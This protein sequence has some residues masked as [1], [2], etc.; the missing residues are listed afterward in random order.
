MKTYILIALFLFPGWG[1]LAQERLSLDDCRQMALQHSERI[2]IARLQ[3]EKARAEEAAMRTSYLPALSAN[4]TGLYLHNSIDMEFTLPTL[5]PDPMTGQLVPNVMTHP[6]S[7]D[8]ITGPDGNPVFNMYAWLP[9]EV[10]L[11]G[12]YLAGLS[13]EQPLYTGGKIAAGHAMTRIAADMA[14]DNLVLQRTNTLFETDQ[15]YWIYVSVQEKVKLATAYATL[16]EELEQQVQHAWETGYVTRNEWLKVAVRHNEARLALQKAQSGLELSRMA[17][18]RLIG[19]PFGTAIETSDEELFSTPQTWLL[20][21]DVTNRPEYRL[22]QRQVD[23]AR[24][25]TKLLRA[26]FLPTAGVSA[27]YTYVGGIDFGTSSYAEGNFSVI[28][29]VSI[30][31]FN[32]GEGRSK[33]QAARHDQA[34][35]QAR[36]EEN[37]GL[38]TLEMEQARLHM[39][40]A[41]KRVEMVEQAMEQAEE[42]LR[43]N[44]DNFELD[45]GVLTD[46]L[47]AQAHWQQAHN[48]LIGALTDLRIKETAWLKATGYL[49]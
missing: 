30:P 11:Q 20:Q 14:G 19:L 29:S 3:I 9:L 32:W 17:L 33:V 25:Q 46:L 1:L 42:N 47:E 12:A 40:D 43:V 23:L 28:A 48:D 45:M 39:A 36:L 27:G 7:G 37:T 4:A 49:E 16:L 2:T 34:I 18:C 35:S 22:M 6:M 21:A 44:Q 41:M 8:V 5:V 10:S 15:A 38:L 13:I 26:G 31:L 24:E